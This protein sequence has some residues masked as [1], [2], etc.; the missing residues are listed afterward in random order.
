VTKETAFEYANNLRFAKSI[1]MEYNDDFRYSG[2][3]A[4]DTVR[5][6]IPVRFVATE[7]QAFQ[8]QAIYETTVPVTLEKQLNVGM[9]WSSAQQTTDLSEIRSRYVSPA[10]MAL[11][12]KVDVY[13]FTNTFLDIYNAVGT[14]GTTPS[15][16][17]TYLQ[18]D[19][20]LFNQAVAEGNHMAVLSG[21]SMATLANANAS[22]FNPVSSVSDAYR[23][24]YQQNDTLGIAKW[25]KSQ[26]VQSYTTGGWGTTSTP[27]VSGANQTGSSLITT[28]W[29]SGTTTLRRGDTFTIA[30]VFTVNPVS[31][32]NTAQLQDFVVTADIS[33]TVGGITIP[34]SP[35]II[36]SG[37]LQT[38]N[39]SPAANAAILVRGASAAAAGTMTATQSAQN[40]LFV[41]DFAT[42]VSAD[43]EM[44]NGGADG[45]RVSSKDWN[46]SIRLVKQYSIMT[47][48]NP[49]R[50]DVL[51][52]AKTINAG[53]ACRIYS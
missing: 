1:S 39:A 30:G 10:A 22:L 51:V 49:S 16:L 50:L 45:S 46:I 27:I 44:P 17:L 8:E 52:G 31:Y 6:R 32:T 14:P 53:R 13:A 42:L 40:L 25:M 36:T 3:K 33:D 21:I 29:N 7:G 35:S 12:N 48:Q 43:L 47:D 18:A 5:V 34:I 37:S 11:A 19:V 20:K 28:G 26:N 2:G 38:V 9:G 4:G 41:K 15:S 23:T 24:G